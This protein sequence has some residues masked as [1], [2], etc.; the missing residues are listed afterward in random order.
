MERLWAPWRL[1]YVTKDKPQGC[2]F[3]TKPKAGDDRANH[4]IHRGEHS[5]V[6]LNTY[7]YNNGHTLISPYAH[8]A[9]LEELPPATL[10]EMMDLAQLVIRAMKDSFRA[11]GFNTGFNLGAVGGAGIQD[12]LHMH[13]VPRW[14][15]D[16]N[17]MP[18]VADVRVIPQ[19][20]DSS[21]DQ[22]L[23]AFRRVEPAV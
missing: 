23:E 2:I 16:T 9:A 8:V 1:S 14:L 6:M 5:Y 7:P 4:I 10:H 18:V 11:G 3:C 21:Y 19:T 15:G 22:L 20:L 17:F 13:I 12:H